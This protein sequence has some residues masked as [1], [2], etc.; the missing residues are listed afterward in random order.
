MRLDHVHAFSS[1]GTRNNIVW[2]EEN[3]WVGYT[4][5][6][7][8]IIEYLNDEKEQRVLSEGNDII[9]SLLLSPNRRMLLAYTATGP[10]DG[11]PCVFVWDSSTLQLLSRL[12]V[13]NE[14]VTCVDFSPNSNLLL[15][16]GFDGAED[17]STISIWDFLDGNHDMLCKSL[18]PA[19]VV[20]GKWNVHLRNL[21]F[22][23]ACDRGY[24]FWRLNENL[25]LEFQ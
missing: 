2:H 9:R 3:R 10:V 13:R 4:Y 25:V 7:T 14:R 16:C 24:H 18:L 19:F 5:C 6:N 23:T 1:K 15:V 20:A 21:E 8:V 17:H 22:A 12:A 11:L